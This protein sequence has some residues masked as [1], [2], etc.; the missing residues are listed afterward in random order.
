MAAVSLFA[1]G[2][3][4][5]SSGPWALL[6]GPAA[7]VHKNAESGY[8]DCIIAMN[9]MVPP[10]QVVWGGFP[11]RELDALSSSSATFGGRGGALNPSAGGCASN[12]I[13]APNGGSLSRISVNSTIAF[14][15]LTPGGI[16]RL[17]ARS[18]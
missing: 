12:L 16:R 13:S 6:P 17:K 4:S 8:F 11:V 2:M 5:F 15:E 3:C 9:G 7:P 10:T 1:V 14:C 18:V